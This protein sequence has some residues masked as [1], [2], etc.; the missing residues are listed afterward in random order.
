MLF[1][2]DPVTDDVA[3]QELRRF[4]ADVKQRMHEMGSSPLRISI[5]TRVSRTTLEHYF[6]GLEKGDRFRVSDDTAKR[7]ANWAKLN[8]SAYEFGR[9]PRTGWHRRPAELVH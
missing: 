4:F 2:Q 1:E 3:Y 9:V 6:A 8:L 5:A 7:L